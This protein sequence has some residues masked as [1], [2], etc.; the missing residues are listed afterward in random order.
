MDEPLD[1]I[2]INEDT[3]IYD[4]GNYTFDYVTDLKFSEAFCKT[5][6]DGILFREN[7]LILA[8]AGIQNAYFHWFAN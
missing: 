6:F 3:K 4:T 8:L 7:K 2:Y 1:T 5:I